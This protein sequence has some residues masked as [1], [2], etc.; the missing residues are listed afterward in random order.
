ML[1]DATDNL[2]CTVTRNA[3]Q[4]STRYEPDVRVRSCED[5]HR[6]HHVC[7]QLGFNEKPKAAMT[8][9][10]LAVHQSSGQLRAFIGTRSQSSSLMTPQ[11]S[12]D[13]HSVRRQKCAPI[14][15]IDTLWALRFS[16]IDRELRHLDCASIA[17]R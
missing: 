13:G 12:E 15:F 16:D 8:A 4:V 10:T 11:P 6:S 2:P 17:F 14:A 7:S 5:V 9:V 3:S 1:G